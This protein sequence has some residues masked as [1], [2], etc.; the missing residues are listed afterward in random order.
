MIEI[1]LAW[2]EMYM[3]ACV[4]VMRQIASMKKGLKHAYGS[5]GSQQWD[6]HIEG[7]CGEC[8][9]A[10]HLNVF[11]DG[12]VNRFKKG[13]DVG[14]NYQVKCLK[15]HWYDLMVRPGDDDDKPYILVTGRGGTYQVHGWA[16]G[17]EAKKKE[18]LERKGG[19]EAA[20][21][22]PQSELHAIK[23]LPKELPTQGV[24]EGALV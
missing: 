12:S 7:A 19:R 6:D 14:K 23:D 8:A 3:A 21:W 10:K 24:L 9:L 5:D 17:H 22:M 18:W 2:H 4:G 20:Y 1:K 11:W 15:A 16:Y 13:G